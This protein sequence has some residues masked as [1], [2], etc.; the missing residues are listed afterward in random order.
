MNKLN[1]LTRATT[2]ILSGLLADGWF[3]FSLSLWWLIRL[4][5]SKYLA[6]ISSNVLTIING[7][8]RQYM[9]CQ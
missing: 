7:M 3:F 2:W 6:D 8:L 4:D 5:K 9:K 1:K